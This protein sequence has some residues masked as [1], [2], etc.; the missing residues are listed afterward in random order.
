MTEWKH[1]LG[2]HFL[3][4]GAMSYILSDEN[5]D[6]DW[7]ED[8][9]KKQQI[10]MV[11]LYKDH[12]RVVELKETN[13]TSHRN[14]K[15]PQIKRY[16][17]LCTCTKYHTEFWAFVYWKRFHTITGYNITSEENTKFMVVKNDGY[18]SFV[19]KE[20]QRKEKERVDFQMKV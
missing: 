6:V 13:S 1:E 17:N 18:V 8:S 5:G 3:Q 19:V 16:Q 14:I 11:V 12:I 2:K 7:G 4:H 10:D 9:N 15:P 20:G